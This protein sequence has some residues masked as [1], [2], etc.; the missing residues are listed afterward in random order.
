MALTATPL[1][2][3][4]LQLGAGVQIAGPYC[5]DFSWPMENSS[6]FAPRIPFVENEMRS[7]DSTL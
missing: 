1:R 6:L 4:K 2:E 7:I 3:L 5:N